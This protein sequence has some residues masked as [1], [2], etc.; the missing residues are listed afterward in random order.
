MS[1]LDVCLTAPVLF[2]L[3][4]AL[5]CA[6]VAAAGVCVGLEAASSAALCCGIILHAVLTCGWCFH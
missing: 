4:G 6:A 2:V 3:P 1:V 5:A